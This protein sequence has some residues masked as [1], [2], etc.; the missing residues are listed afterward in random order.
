MLQTKLPGNFLKQEKDIDTS[1]LETYRLTRKRVHNRINLLKKMTLEFGS[2][3]EKLEH[4]KS[5]LTTK[6]KPTIKCVRA[7]KGA[8]LDSTVSSLCQ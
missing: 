4:R 8:N 6:I 5:M 7:S 2:Y 1:M 3:K